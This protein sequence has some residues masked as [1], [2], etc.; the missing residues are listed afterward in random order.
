MR[1]VIYLIRPRA[2]KAAYD[3]QVFLKYIASLSLGKLGYSV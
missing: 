2:F 1:R 3:H